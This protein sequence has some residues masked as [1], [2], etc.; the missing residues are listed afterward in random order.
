MILR[1]LKTSLF[2][3]RKSFSGY[4]QQLKLSC[5]LLSLSRATICLGISAC[6][7]YFKCWHLI[8]SVISSHKKY[9]IELMWAFNFPLTYLIAHYLYQCQETLSNAQN[10]GYLRQDASL[11]VMFSISVIQK[12][13]GRGAFKSCVWSASWDLLLF[14]V[15]AMFWRLY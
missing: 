12:R 4:Q 8:P 11:R 7:Y 15:K 2:T 1:N 6:P 10:P 3:L 5:F 14:L 9:Y 13:L